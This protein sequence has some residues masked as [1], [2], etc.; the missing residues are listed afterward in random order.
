MHNISLTV[1]ESLLLLNCSLLQY[2]QLDDADLDSVIGVSGEV[3]NKAQHLLIEAI[4]MNISSGT[5]ASISLQIDSDTLT[6]L[7][8]FASQG[9]YWFNPDLLVAS[10]SDAYAL[11]EFFDS[12]PNDTEGLK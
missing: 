1:K 2:T 9:G 8:G 4:R 5:D 10:Q 12:V 7:R 6:A 3:R 11:M